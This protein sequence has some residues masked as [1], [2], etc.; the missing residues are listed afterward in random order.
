MEVWVK[1]GYTCCDAHMDDPN[2]NN[3]KNI[4]CQKTQKA[5]QSNKVWLDKTQDVE[6][7]LQRQ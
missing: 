4:L 3:N 2:Q 1:Q 5:Q 7:K 6:L